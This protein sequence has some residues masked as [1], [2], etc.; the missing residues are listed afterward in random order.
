MHVRIPKKFLRN[1]SRSRVVLRT[2]FTGRDR[3]RKTACSDL[4]KCWVHCSTNNIGICFD[5]QSASVRVSR[6]TRAEAGK[7]TMSYEYT[8]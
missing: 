5:P 3:T 7:E 4:V 6:L 1:L 2:S 8:C